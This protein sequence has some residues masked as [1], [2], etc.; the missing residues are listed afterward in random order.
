MHSH[1]VSGSDAAY[2]PLPR[3][4]APLLPPGNAISSYLQLPSP[5]GASSSASSGGFLRSDPFGALLH[6]SASTSQSM[7]TSMASSSMVSFSAF[8]EDSTPSRTPTAAG[9][10]ANPFGPGVVF[11]SPSL[12]TSSQD[13]LP[14]LD[15]REELAQSHVEMTARGLGSRGAAGLTPHHQG[16][17][18]MQ[19]FESGMTARAPPPR[20]GLGI[21]LAA[22]NELTPLEDESA[23]RERSAEA[24]PIE[25][26]QEHQLLV[27]DLLVGQ[28]ITSG[29]Q[30]SSPSLQ[31]LAAGAE[32]V[33]AGLGEREE[34]GTADDVEERRNSISE[35]VVSVSD[36]TTVGHNNDSGLTDAGDETIA[37]P[38]ATLNESQS[39]LAEETRAF[40]Q[41]D[42]ALFETLQKSR[43]LPMLDA[44]LAH[45]S[46]TALSLESDAS[47]LPK[48]DPRF[49]IYGEVSS[50]AVP[51]TAASSVT[52]SSSSGAA[53]K[54]K[55]G[56]VML[57][58]SIERWI[59]Q[60]TAEMDFDELL[61]FF[62][63][64]R[65]YVSPLDLAHLLIS[66]FHWALERGVSS[67]DDAIKKV[68]RLRTFVAMRFW[69][70]K[71][72]DTDFVNN[73]PL[74]VYISA[75]LNTIKRDKILYVHRDAAVS[76]YFCSVETTCGSQRMTIANRAPAFQDR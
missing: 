3:G 50:A 11:D 9:G 34:E 14:Q 39:V 29:G 47:P 13:Q 1:T 41:Y 37:A 31:Q 16:L 25:P 22:K 48:S 76:I 21:G 10:F 7:D 30:R 6:K 75:W 19:S 17:R 64:Y 72:F 53:S 62:L 35:T 24:S 5:G 49:V 60:L 40:S 68:V 54:D 66:R 12:P 69:L 67:Q 4:T 15:W 58:A 65:T 27:N 23:S 33:L 32:A 63:T 44:A 55:D 8:G 57:A 59:A 26:S 28:H 46:T 42:Y 43:G 70:V 51:G 71:F 45:S 52:G 20:I 38:Q 74:R 56:K 73:A 61:V 2:A 36:D 18:V